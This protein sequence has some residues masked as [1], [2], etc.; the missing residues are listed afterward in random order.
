MQFVLNP[1]P[2]IFTG[3]NKKTDGI[4]YYEWRY[5]QKIL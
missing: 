3:G 1:N 2:L 5:K 4:Q